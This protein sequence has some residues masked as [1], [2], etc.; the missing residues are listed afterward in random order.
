MSRLKAP[1]GVCEMSRPGGVRCIYIYMLLVI[2]YVNLLLGVLSFLHGLI[3]DFMLMISCTICYVI[4]AC[5][6]YGIEQDIFYTYE[7][8][9]Y[10]CCSK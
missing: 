3:I 10:D 1:S 9:K 7:V 8:Q 5:E 6:R 4:N 2:Y